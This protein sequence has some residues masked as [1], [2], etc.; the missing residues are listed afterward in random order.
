RAGRAR[1]QHAAARLRADVADRAR[2]GADTVSTAVATTVGEA[3]SLEAQLQRTTGLPREQLAALRARGAES[4]R[5]LL[6]VLLDERLV[7]PE[8]ALAAIGDELGLAVRPAIDAAA[9]DPSLVDRVP[10]AFAK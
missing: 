8:R 7:D 4:G 6:D 5:T 3:L 10:I 9:C 2:T 1:G